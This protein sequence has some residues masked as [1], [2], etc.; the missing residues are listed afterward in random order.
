MDAGIYATESTYLERYV[1]LGVAGDRVISLSFPK[2]PDEDAEADHPLFERITAY[3]E[4]VEDDFADVPV[5]LTLPTD[6]RAVLE[7]AREIGYG[8]QVGVEA[9]TRMT[10]GLDADE[11]EDRQL[12]RTA[13]AE[14]PVPMLIPDHRVRDAPSGAPADVEQKLRSLEGL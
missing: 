4:G 12:V 2:D 6:Q 8:E 3:L 5:G 1:Q 14:N 7:K 13:L 10:P 9:L 11:D